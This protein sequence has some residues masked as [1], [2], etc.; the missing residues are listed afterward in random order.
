MNQSYQSWW[1]ETVRIF[2]LYLAVTIVALPFGIT[3]G[4]VTIYV[5]D[6]WI[7]AV[8]LIG[9]GTLTGLFVWN[10]FEKLQE[11]KQLQSLQISILI[12]ERE[13]YKKFAVPTLAVVDTPLKFYSINTHKVQ[14]QKNRLELNN[15]TSPPTS[16]GAQ[17]HLILPYYPIAA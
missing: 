12:N 10:K 6:H 13:L 7:V 15:V 16:S 1:H 4:L 14:E 8:T 2:K 9:F 17:N 3:Y 11:I 5:M